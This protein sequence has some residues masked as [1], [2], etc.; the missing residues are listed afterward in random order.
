MDSREAASLRKVTCQG[1]VIFPER[2]FLE[3]DDSLLFTIVQEL[4]SQML[5][6]LQS[7][8]KHLNFECLFPIICPFPA[9]QEIVK[10]FCRWSCISYSQTFNPRAARSHRT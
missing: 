5:K 9:F 6:F 10:H 4:F 3:A 7:R 8:C 1:F 2:F